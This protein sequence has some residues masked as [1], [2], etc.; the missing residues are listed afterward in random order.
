[1]IILLEEF[2]HLLKPSLVALVKE[3]MHNATVGDGYR[4]GG[5][6]GDNCK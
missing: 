5:V 2:Q 1:M 6:N 3:S 4:V